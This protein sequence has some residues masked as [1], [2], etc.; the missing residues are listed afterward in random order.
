MQREVLDWVIVEES[1]RADDYLDKERESL[2]RIRKQLDR[3]RPLPAGNYHGVEI[4][5]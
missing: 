3:G 1:K 4:V 5:E 2:Q